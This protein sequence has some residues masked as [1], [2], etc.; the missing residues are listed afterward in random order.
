M[1]RDLALLR[2]VLDVD[3]DRETRLCHWREWAAAGE[4]DDHSHQAY[5][6]FP[7]AYIALTEIGEDHRWLARLKGVHRQAW[8]RNTLHQAA[9]EEA[10]TVLAKAGLDHIQPWPTD[11]AGAA[12]GQPTTFTL[13]DPRIVVR[14]A[15]AGRAE[16]SFV[17]SGWTSEPAPPG[18]LGPLGVIQRFDRLFT[19]DESGATIRL[20]DHLLPGESGK[21]RADAPWSRAAPAATA[22][23]HRA[24]AADIARAILTEP[25]PE[26]G[27]YRWA[28][29]LAA[30]LGTSEPTASVELAP[31]GDALGTLARRRLD[32]YAEVTGHRVDVVTGLASATSGGAIRLVRD[33]VRAARR[34][35]HGIR[36]LRGHA[37]TLAG[38]SLHRL[39]RS[40]GRAARH[41]GFRSR[42]ADGAGGRAAP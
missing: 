37:R 19:N 31:D 33:E 16:R 28:L 18:G 21:A 26:G 34:F 17:T 12:E 42:P 23:C 2:F 4:I 41:L 32:C 11:L 35:D 30:H 22:H 25:E 1:S 36:D 8:T 9:R 14:W 10:L 27:S 13:P 38:Y 39:R 15:D 6:L 5:D 7:A 29:E 3:A 40:P 20:A 24:S